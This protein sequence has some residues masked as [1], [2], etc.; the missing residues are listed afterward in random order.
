ML[1]LQR[2]HPHSYAGNIDDEKDAF[3]A[4][5]DVKIIQRDPKCQDRSEGGIQ[6][7]ATIGEYST[8]HLK[9]V[10]G[11]RFQHSFS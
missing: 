6:T 9:N 10:N 3:Y 5:L 8:Y 11:P 1:Q 2:E 4:Q 7:D